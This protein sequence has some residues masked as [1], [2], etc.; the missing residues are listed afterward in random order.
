MNIN[1]IKMVRAKDNF[2]QFYS[3]LDMLAANNHIINAA[4]ALNNA[5]LERIEE[6]AIDFA[7]YATKK[8]E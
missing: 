1:L 5:I 4:E 8:E 6:L 7:D 2:D 3:K